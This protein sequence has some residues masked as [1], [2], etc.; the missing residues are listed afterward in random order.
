MALLAAI[1]AA[2]AMAGG[3][4]F[5]HG[6]AW[7]R[8][9]A[10]PDGFAFGRKV[11]KVKSEERDGFTLETWRQAN[12]PK[13]FQDVLVAV[14]Q[15]AKG[16]LPAVVI[17]AEDGEHLFAADLVKRGYV[18]VSSDCGLS[19]KDALGWSGMGRLAHNARLLVDFA[20]ADGRIDKERI[21]MA[22][23]RAGGKIA[24][25]AGLLDARVKAVGVGFL[26]VALSHPSWGEA[27]FWGDEAKAMLEARLSNSDLLVQSGGKPVFFLRGHG[28][29][30]ANG[31]SGF[32]WAALAENAKSKVGCIRR[33]ARTD[34][35]KPGR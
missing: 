23:A 16:C 27:R 20:A 21:G 14:P 11:E 35:R 1:G 17:P 9:F 8:R 24:Y 22:G 3:V 7:G 6:E 34:D 29:D 31:D 32:F 26:D 10:A 30:D 15:G 33:Y 13:S 18:T 4:D 5:P 28:N 19:A 2:A 12:G 25:C